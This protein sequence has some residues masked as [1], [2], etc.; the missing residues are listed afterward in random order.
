[1]MNSMSAVAAKR[2]QIAK[3]AAD[4]G[5]LAGFGATHTLVVLHDKGAGMLSKELLVPTAER[6]RSNCREDE[7]GLQ[8]ARWWHLHGETPH[9]AQGQ[10]VARTF[11]T[12]ESILD[13]ETCANSGIRKGE[14]DC[15]HVRDPQ[16]PSVHATTARKVAR[17]DIRQSS[18][19][20]P[21]PFKPEENRFSRVSCEASVRIWKL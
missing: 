16:G 2:L 4:R 8:D 18:H 7:K 17:C 6:Q 15:E 21:P 20:M 9:Q 11:Q 12:P 1:M 13:A 19:P 14:T 10:G 5:S 3:L